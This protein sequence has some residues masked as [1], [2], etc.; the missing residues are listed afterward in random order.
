VKGIRFGL[1][2][3]G[4]CSALS[5][6][7]AT[8]SVTSP[9][10]GKWLGSTN[11]LSFN[12]SGAHVQVSVKAVI[13]GPGGSTTVSTNVNPDVNGAF[14]GTLPL[15]FSQNVA[16]GSYTLAVTATEPGNTYTP[17]NL[18]VLVDT[19]TPK[20]LEYS[21][22][23]NSFSKGN[24]PIFFKVLENNMK[25]WRVTVG[26]S[27]IPNNTGTTETTIMVN[28]DSSGLDVDGSQNIAL[29]AKDQADNT[30]SFSIPLTI[31]RKPPSS[32]IQFPQSSSPVRPRTN[33]NVLVDIT[34]QFAGSVDLTGIDVVVQNI[35]GTLISRASRL[36]WT[37]IGNSTW[38]WSGR[39][40]YVKT[41]PS[42]FKIVVSAIDKAG[43]LAIRQE[44]TVHPS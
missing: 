11:T 19:K 24:V 30:L 20:L 41:L 3:A 38:R 8:F 13:T 42:T 37:N 6:F 18:N 32:V 17:V 15:N 5:A 40:R 29:T 34:D 33:I 2:C 39:I 28:Y 36:A 31:D 4:I 12:G 1:I 44:V 7:A 9:T 10:E 14:T 27:D 43:N 16:Q 26:G 22:A 25:E 35:N 21:P 23:Q